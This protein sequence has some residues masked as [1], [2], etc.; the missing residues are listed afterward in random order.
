MG[1]FLAVFVR[2]MLQDLQSGDHRRIELK[3]CR[4]ADAVNDAREP[5]SASQVVL[6]RKSIAKPF[7]SRNFRLRKR[8]EHAELNDIARAYIW[9]L[10][11]TLFL[12]LLPLFRV[13]M[14]E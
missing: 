12:N 9:D 14:C 13:D 1:Q 6:L 4:E 5:H 8:V 10:K 2:A 7:E 11:F 3:L